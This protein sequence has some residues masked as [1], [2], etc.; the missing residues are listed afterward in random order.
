MY[1]CK[2]K[3][4]RNI[5]RASQF[6][7]LDCLLWVR[8][9]LCWRQWAFCLKS[10]SHLW[11]T[12]GSS[13]TLLAHHL[14][15]P[16]VVGTMGTGHIAHGHQGVPLSSYK[17]AALKRFQIGKPCLWGGGQTESYTMAVLQERIT[18]GGSRAWGLE[19]LKK[20]PEPN[21]LQPPSKYM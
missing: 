19:A 4:E 8:C 14:Q 17:T 13:R 15:Q 6:Q 7:P 2:G 11:T 3:S 1:Q 18:T 12:A 16:L 5:E 9:W 20:R 10:G 21:W